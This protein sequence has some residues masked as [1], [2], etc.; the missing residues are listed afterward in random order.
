MRDL[1]TD[2]PYHNSGC[3]STGKAE[4]FNAALA[5]ISTRYNRKILLHV[6]Q[7]LLTQ[8]SGATFQAFQFP[9]VF[10]NFERSAFQ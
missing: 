9:I 7:F 6:G 4:N 1:S 5:Q 3:A 10:H 8:K 2:E